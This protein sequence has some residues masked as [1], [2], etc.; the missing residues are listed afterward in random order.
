MKKHYSFDEDLQRGIQEGLTKAVKLV[1]A[2]LGPAGRTILLREK[3]QPPF[4]TK[5]GVSVAKRITFEDP[6]EDLGAQMV[7]QSAESTN[8]TSGDGTSTTSVLTE[9]LYRHASKHI[10]AGETPQAIKRGLENI[11]ERIVEAIKIRKKEVSSWDDIYQ[12]ALVSANGDEK[13]ARMLLEGMKA[14]GMDGNIKI[15]PANTRLDE[16]EVQD[17]FQMNSGL[18]AKVLATDKIRELARFKDANIFVTD[19]TLTTTEHIAPIIATAQRDGKPFAIFCEDVGQEALAML[20]IN[21]QR[22]NCEGI[23]VRGQG[24]GQERRDILRDLAIACGAETYS[25]EEHGTFENVSIKHFGQ[26]DL[27][28]STNYSTVIAGGKANAEELEQRL[29]TLRQQVKTEQNPAIGEVLEERI[30]RLS[31]GVAIVHVGGST[32]AEQKERM[33]R[34]EDALQAIKASQ[35][36]GIIPGGGTAFLNLKL[37]TKD[38]N[39]EEKLAWDI[40]SKALEE[41][42]R[43]IVENAGL[44]ADTHLEKMKKQ[45]L[46][47][48]FDVRQ[49]KFVNL[50]EAGI[51]D[52]MK[53]AR[54]V[55]ENAISASTT[56]LLSSGAIISLDETRKN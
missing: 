31:S 44:N 27:V 34:F 26:V 12:V 28:E 22:K 8:K 17:G 47:V 5:D 55:I 24:F 19:A 6:V 52:P 15:T 41:P 54:C 18:G 3:G 40:L 49:E 23:I 33:D 32:P 50:F 9:A 51:I 16:L 53:T 38:F 43:K 46:N 14:I 37:S 4:A 56:L 20:I 30:T 10:I 2:T 48:G 29:T 39:N 7:R 35:E 25:L 36:E 21:V 11:Q 42:F 1:S 13:I 45:K